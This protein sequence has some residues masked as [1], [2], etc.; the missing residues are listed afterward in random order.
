VPGRGRAGGRHG[1]F[2]LYRP[3]TRVPENLLRLGVGLILTSVGAF[4]GAEGAVAV[5][6]VAAPLARG[7]LRRAV[8]R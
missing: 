1:G 6:V 7:S 2:I 5:L 3:L 4:W 8:G